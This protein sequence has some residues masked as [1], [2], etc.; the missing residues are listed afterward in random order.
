MPIRLTV[1]VVACTI[2]Y[3]AAGMDDFHA[4]NHAMSTVATGSGALAPH[5]EEKSRR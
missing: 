3:T 2:S 1:K 5:R 4:I